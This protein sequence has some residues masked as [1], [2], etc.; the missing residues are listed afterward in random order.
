M[1]HKGKKADIDKVDRVKADSVKTTVNKEH[2]LNSI[3]NNETIKFDFGNKGEADGY[4]KVDSSTKY[5]SNT[6]YG[7]NTPDRIKDID[8]NGE[9]ELEDAVLFEK[10]GVASD[11]TFDVDL[12]DGLYE[13]TVKMGPIHD[14]SRIVAEE[15]LQEFNIDLAGETRTFKV[16]VSDG[17]LN[18]LATSSFGADGEYSLSSLDITKV[19]SD[20]SNKTNIW[21]CGDSTVANYDQRQDNPKCGWGQVLHEFVDTSKY[22]I[23][24]FS[25]G[26]QYAKEFLEEDEFKPIEH[27]GKKG[28]YFVMVLGG[29]DVTASNPDEFYDCVSYMTDICKEKEMEVIYIQQPPLSDAVSLTPDLTD[30]W[31]NKQ[32]GEMGE[33]KDVKVVDLFNP[34]FNFFKSIGQ[35][36][37]FTYFVKGDNE[38]T[39]M[40]GARYIANLFVEGAGLTKS[41]K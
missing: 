12:P 7:F 37:T 3:N 30:Y 28:D 18:I 23:R 17:K 31:S 11:N 1:I 22:E 32:L 39:N 38:H 9:N 5:L 33:E 34:S 16:P 36:E 40:K 20:L 15:Y 10:Y 19:P 14:R 13:I 8:S 2:I 25:S 21:L 6:G 4:I 35:E 27:Y 24:N 26:G 29:N 41:N